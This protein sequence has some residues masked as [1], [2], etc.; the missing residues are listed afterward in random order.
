MALGT[1]TVQT[2]ALTSNAFSSSG[3]VFP[4]IIVQA[5][6]YCSAKLGGDIAG[7]GNVGTNFVASNDNEGMAVAQL[8]ASMLENGKQYSKPGGIPLTID[9]LYTTEIENMLLKPDEQ[10]ETQFDKGVA[11]DN[12]PPSAFAERWEIP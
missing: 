12:D 7:T 9:E 2:E 6:H 3:T 4:L 8:A 11:W 10:D 5:Y 1:L